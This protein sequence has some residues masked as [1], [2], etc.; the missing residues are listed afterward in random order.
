[1]ILLMHLMVC[2]CLQNESRARELVDQIFSLKVTRLRHGN[3]VSVGVIVRNEEM[4]EN[5]TPMYDLLWQLR[6]RIWN[7]A[8]WPLREFDIV[9]SDIPFED[10]LAET[11]AG[12]LL[13]VA[14]EA[15]SRST[16]NGDLHT[17]FPGLDETLTDDL[18]IDFNWEAW[19]T[20]TGNFF[21]D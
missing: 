3:F 14:S 5:M 13:A 1:M 16:D 17:L 19:E 10:P 2:P 9:S 6:R 11:K 21:Q 15:L 8:R 20:F 4:P 7:K 12:A 18:M